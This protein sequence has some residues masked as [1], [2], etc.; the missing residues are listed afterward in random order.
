M[1]RRGTPASRYSLRRRAS[2]NSPPRR[3]LVASRLD[4][5]DRVVP[6]A[7][8]CVAVDPAAGRA[9]VEGEQ[10]VDLGHAVDDT[11]KKVGSVL[12]HVGDSLISRP[13]SA[14]PCESMP[15]PVRTSRATMRRPR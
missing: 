5:D 7:G 1:R 13:V 10:A 15:H 14:G 4:A 2:T 6:L 9:G 8:P 12:V 3:E 11:I